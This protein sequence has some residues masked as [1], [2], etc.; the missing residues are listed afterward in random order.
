MN[1]SLNLLQNYSFIFVQPNIFPQIT[2][3]FIEIYSQIRVFS[4]FGSKKR[5]KT[6]SRDTIAIKIK[7]GDSTNQFLGLV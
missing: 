7:K 1:I 5:A 4:E 6:I 3:I 2:A